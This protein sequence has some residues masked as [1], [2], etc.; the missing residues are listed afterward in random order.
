MPRK[1]VHTPL[2]SLLLTE[3]DGHLTDICWSHTQE[4]ATTPVLDSAADEIH[5]FLT[6]DRKTFTLPYKFS[7]G[8]PF[9]KKVW[10]EIATIPYGETRTYG[11][12]AEALSS[13]ARAIGTACGKNPLPIV[14]PCHRV[15]GKNGSL[16]GYSG[17]E[18]TETKSRLLA[19]EKTVART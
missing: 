2:G 18:G 15:V 6:A 12:L 19:L 8:T 13:H 4:E 10:Q 3:E 16:T 5:A 1:T 9:Q 7:R 14:V 11:Q 17:G